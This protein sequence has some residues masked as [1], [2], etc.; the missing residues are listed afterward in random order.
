M[1]FIN[2]KVIKSFVTYNTMGKNMHE[3]L[4][5]VYFMSIFLFIFLDSMNING[6]PFFLFLYFLRNILPQFNYIH[7][8]TFFI[9]TGVLEC[10][11]H[12]ECE[13]KRCPA[14]LEP[15]CIFCKCK[16]IETNL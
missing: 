14:P 12:F 7:L 2:Y 10:T 1:R 5:F 3:I 6:K 11:S 16:C 15:R 13:K 8:F 4:K 9:A